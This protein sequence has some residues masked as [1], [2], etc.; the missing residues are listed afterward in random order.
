M[1][2]WPS[3]GRRRQTTEAQVLACSEGTWLPSSSRGKLSP[4]AVEEYWAVS[5]SQSKLPHRV[6]FLAY[7]ALQWACDFSQL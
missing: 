5:T 7:Q 4:Q 6:F 1:R 2:G 3:G